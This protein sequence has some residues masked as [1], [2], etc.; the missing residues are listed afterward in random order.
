[1]YNTTEHS[2]TGFTPF[3]LLF[4][5]PSTLPSALKKPPERQYNY[6]DYASELRGRLQTVHQHA[7]KNLIES[8]GRSKEHY[9][10]TTGQTKLQVGDKVLLFDETVHRGRSRKL[11]AQWVRPYTIP[12]LDKVNATIARGS[13]STKVHVN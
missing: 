5:H 3:E 7:H 10:K 1:V 12:E 9:E 13:K 11:S 6:D 4:G 2:A 8:K